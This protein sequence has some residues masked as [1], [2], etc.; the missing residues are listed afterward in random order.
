MKH[1]VLPPAL[2]GLAI[3]WRLSLPVMRTDAVTL[4][5]VRVED[6]A[7]LFA[8]LA[9][10][11]VARFISPPPATLEGFVRFIERALQQRLAGTCACYAVVPAGTKRRPRQRPSA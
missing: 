1:T 2:A 3:E 6:A 5:E 7:S 11:E 10:E 8:M 9:T 4:R